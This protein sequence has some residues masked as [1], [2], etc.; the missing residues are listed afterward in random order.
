MLYLFISYNVDKHIS[1]KGLILLGG[2]VSS[3]LRDIVLQ[4]YCLYIVNCARARFNEFC[5]LLSVMWIKY[6]LALALYCTVLYC[7]VL[8]CIAL[9]CIF[10][11][12]FFINIYSLQYL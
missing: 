3:L 5:K 4:F 8:Y 2:V 6:C 9:Y 12:L 1:F 10:K 11:E 7:T